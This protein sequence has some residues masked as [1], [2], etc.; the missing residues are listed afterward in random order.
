MYHHIETMAMC[1]FCKGLTEL[2]VGGRASYRVALSRSNQV[3]HIDVD[4]ESPLKWS[5]ASVSTAP[6]N[7]AVVLEAD[8]RA[9]DA[10]FASVCRSMQNSPLPPA[11]VKLSVWRDARIVGSRYNS[12]QRA[13]TEPRGTTEPRCAHIRRIASG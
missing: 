5:M 11:A 13:T 2:T 9:V 8:D 1:E 3:L 10:A 7:I 12:I 4:F 6:T